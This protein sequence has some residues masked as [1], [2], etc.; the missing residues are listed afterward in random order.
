MRRVDLAEGERRAQ[1]RMRADVRHVDTEAV[2]RTADVVAEAVRTD[3]GH[4]AERRPSRRRDGDVGRAAAEHL[5]E[6]PDVGQR[7]AHL[8]GVQVD[9]HAAHGEDLEAARGLSHFAS[10]VRRSR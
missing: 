2:E 4:H 9:A 3:L 8:L 5:P 10:R 1:G 7:H 6:A